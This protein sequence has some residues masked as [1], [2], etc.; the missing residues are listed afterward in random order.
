MS[1]VRTAPVTLTTRESAL[2]ARYLTEVLGVLYPPPCTAEPA[3]ATPAGVA[4]AAGT[5]VADFHA[6]PDVRRARLLVPAGTPRIAAA[7]VQAAGAPSARLGRLKR[8]MA[9]AALRAGLSSLVMP[10]RVRI[11]RPAD[12]GPLD[13]IETYLAQQLRRE[14]AVSVHIGPARPSRKPLVQLLTPQGSTFGFAKLGVN[15]LTTRLVRL[16]GAALTA[17][18]HL[19][20]PDVV[21][22]QVLH[23]GRWRGHEVLVQ[24]ALPAWTR[25]C[26]VSPARLAAAQRAIAFGMG[27][28]RGPLAASRYWQVLRR[29]ITVAGAGPSVPRPATEPDAAAGPPAAGESVPVESVRL[30]P[31][32]VEPVPGAEQA[33]SLALAADLLVAAL[34]DVELRYGAWHGDW[35]PWNMAAQDYGLLLWDW[36]RFGTGVPVGFDALHYDLHRRMR[37]S[38]DAR[39]AVHEL[40][41]RAEELLA[42]FDVTRPAAAR[43]TSLLYLIDLATRYLEDKRAGGRLGVLG[44]WLLPELLSVVEER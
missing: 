17:L 7:A 37:H 24:A 28:C 29:R 6:V 18:H 14:L 41:D 8:G 26:P 10:D 42:P 9:A 4:P 16:E 43:L 3:D 44:T 22:A 11:T 2:R 15:P 1:P 19:A 27:N 31:V 25:R 32:P 33:R 34:G 23:S 5:L 38:Q 35:T 36:D 40:L 20:P 30:E 12:A 13:T 39:V 21:T